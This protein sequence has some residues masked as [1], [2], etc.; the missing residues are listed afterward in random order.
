MYNKVF[1]YKKIMGEVSLVSE[2][3]YQDILHVQ[4]RIY[5]MAT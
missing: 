5:A 3:L 4:Y 2:S 1:W